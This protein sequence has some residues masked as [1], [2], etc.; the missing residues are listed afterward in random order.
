MLKAVLPEGEKD[1]INTPTTSYLFSP[2]LGTPPTP[3]TQVTDSLVI[4]VVL[5]EGAKNIKV[6]APFGDRVAM[7]METK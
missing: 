3:P 6:D 1:T 7:S 4:K 2:V 5:P